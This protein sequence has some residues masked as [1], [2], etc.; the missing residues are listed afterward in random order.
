ML[1]NHKP[2]LD[3]S[4]VETDSLTGLHTTVNMCLQ[5][6]RDGVINYYSIYVIPMSKLQILVS[7]TKFH[8]VY[9]S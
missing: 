8:S 1:N 2:H 7:F 5:T 9:F 4:Y 3:T 6:I